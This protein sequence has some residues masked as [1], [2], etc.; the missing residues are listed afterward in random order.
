MLRRS[1]L[2]SRRQSNPGPGSPLRA[3]AS[4]RVVRSA[5]LVEY[6]PGFRVDELASCHLVHAD[7][8]KLRPPARDFRTSLLNQSA[9]R[10][11]S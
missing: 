7:L 4:D 8:V 5:G 1:S 11:V 6:L 10:K 3:P 9:E 2:A